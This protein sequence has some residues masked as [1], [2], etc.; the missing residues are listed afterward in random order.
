MFYNKTINCITLP[1]PKA[2]PV[3]LVTRS[4]LQAQQSKWLSETTGQIF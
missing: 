4:K 3:S 2:L 1:Q